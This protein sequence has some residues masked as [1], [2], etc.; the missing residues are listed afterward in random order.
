MDIQR[1]YEALT[2]PTPPP[3]LEPAGTP[4]EL[5]THLSLL[6]KIE[7][8]PLFG[9][10][11]T[12]ADLCNRF[13]HD[14]VPLYAQSVFKKELTRYRAWRRALFDLYLLDVGV[15]PDMDEIAAL[16]RI[17]RLEYTAK[18]HQE[19]SVLRRTLPNGWRICGLNAEAALNLDKALDPKDRPQ[20][21]RALSVVDQLQTAQLAKS[22]QHL[23][24]TKLIGKLPKP[25]SHVYHAPLPPKLTAEFVDG[26]ALL[27]AAMPF[28]Y[29]L[30][31]LTKA[32]SADDDPTLDELALRLKPIY[33]IDPAEH[34]FH[35]P[36]KANFQVYIRHIWKYSS[37]GP[38]VPISTLSPVEKAWAEF[39]RQLRSHGKTDMIP[40]THHVSKYA[41]ADG[42]APHELNQA[43]FAVID[44]GLS[45]VDSRAFRSGAFFFDQLRQSDCLPHHLLPRHASGIVRMRKKTHT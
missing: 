15:P 8:V 3:H 21:R 37:L 16:T 34:G 31:V 38:Y 39:R 20:F 18:K 5:A 6:P 23:L 35:S 9:L 24:P 27:K 22:V 32:L 4:F 45:G 7:G 1:L 28:C 33:D 43:W 10:T 44:R 13:P 2:S 11:Y 30:A 19:L 40:R 42:L 14:S 36:T 17:A 12:A 26:E 41:I 29:R 25:S